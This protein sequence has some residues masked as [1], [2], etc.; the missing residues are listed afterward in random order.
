MADS[1][2][3]VEDALK[4][5]RAIELDGL[6]PAH[7]HLAAIAAALDAYTRTAS[8]ELNAE[9]QVLLADAAAAMA[10]HVQYGRVLPASLVTAG[11]WIRA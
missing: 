5:V 6:E 2:G 9:L 8:N 1:A 10:D 7:Y 3:G 4:A 11:M